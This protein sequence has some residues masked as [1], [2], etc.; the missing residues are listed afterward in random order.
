VIYITVPS[1]VIDINPGVAIDILPVIVSVCG[2]ISMI[3]L[4]AVHDTYNVN[5][6]GAILIY[7]VMQPM[8]IG[9]PRV[10]LFNLTGT[11]VVVFKPIIYAIVPSGVTRI[12]CGINPLPQFIVATDL[13]DNVT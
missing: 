2:E 11:T 10:M 12:N 9:I 3:I 8:F 4:L 1:G 6:L 5:P 7:E 13:F